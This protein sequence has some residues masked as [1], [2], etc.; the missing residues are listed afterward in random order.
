[1]RQGR[2][3]NTDSL[4]RAAKDQTSHMPGSP[5]F[6]GGGLRPSDTAVAKLPPRD[7]RTL[8]ALPSRPLSAAALQQYVTAL[9]KKLT[10][11]L[12][13]AYG[14]TIRN[15]DRYN[16]V[17]VS[18]AAAIAT[19]MGMLDQA[20]L[21]ALKA[22]EREPDNPAVL[23]NAGV[24]L[25]KGGLEIAAIPLLEAAAVSDPGNSTVQNNLGQS[26][27]TL[28]D[29]E[30]ASQHFTS[31]LA[32]APY[33][34]LANSSLA[35]IE[36]VEALE[37]ELSDKVLGFRIDD[38]DLEIG[39]ALREHAVDRRTQKPRAVLHGHNDAHRRV[40]HRGHPSSMSTNSDHPARV[41]RGAA[42]PF[43]GGDGTSLPRPV[44][45][46]ASARMIVVLQTDIEA[47]PEDP[48]VHAADAAAAGRSRPECTV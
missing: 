6:G 23:N 20:V 14:T 25:H 38:E 12:L 24:I 34:P 10:P 15:T 13:Q 46:P 4:I 11:A 19:E 30:K 44:R 37:G 47:P 22:V 8:G 21:L 18:N 42:T 33:H 32:A 27:L 31:C 17:A 36:L 9:D 28:G 41:P 5:A 7:T 40:R 2:A 16:A 43:V 39:K 29:R 26:Y 35:L 48:P 45:R 3:V 1:M